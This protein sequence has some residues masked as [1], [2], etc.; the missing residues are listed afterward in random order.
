MFPPV[1]D[2]PSAELSAELGRQGLPGAVLG[3]PR[4]SRC[5]S[6]SEPREVAWATVAPGGA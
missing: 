1:P 5:K 6:V 2:R 4:T 3:G